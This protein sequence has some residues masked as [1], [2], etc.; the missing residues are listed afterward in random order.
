[1]IIVEICIYMIFASKQLKIE[2][3]RLSYYKKPGISEKVFGK[4]DSPVGT[5][6]SG[7]FQVNIHFRNPTITL[8]KIFLLFPVLSYRQSHNKSPVYPV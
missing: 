7:S 8:C 1:M 4:L 3:V 5:L 2:N 6:F